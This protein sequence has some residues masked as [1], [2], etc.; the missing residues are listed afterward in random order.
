[1]LTRGMLLL[2]HLLATFLS[3]S[4]FSN[5]YCLGVV[6]PPTQNIE[7]Q[8][9]FQCLKAEILI[10][11]SHFELPVQYGIAFYTHTPTHP[12]THPHTHTVQKRQFGMVVKVLAE[13]ARDFEF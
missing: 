6:A 4:L 8:R 3:C 12:H 7:T 5:I 2:W 11:C 10:Q 13:K 9:L 1:M